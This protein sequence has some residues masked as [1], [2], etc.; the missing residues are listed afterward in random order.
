MV[1]AR[2]LG[3]QLWEGSRSSFEQTRKAESS[4]ADPMGSSSSNGTA[5]GSSLTY[6]GAPPMTKADIEH[7]KKFME[8]VDE[9][10]A[11]RQK[12]KKEMEK[13]SLLGALYSSYD[14]LYG[15][16]AIGDVRSEEKDLDGLDGGVADGEEGSTL[17]KRSRKKAKV[18]SQPP[19]PHLFTMVL[20]NITWRFSG[21]RFS[22]TNSEPAECCI[23]F[24]EDH[25]YLC[26]SNGLVT[27][28]DSEGVAFLSGEPDRSEWDICDRAEIP[29]PNTH[30]VSSMLRLLR[31]GILRCEVEGVSLSESGQVDVS[32]R[33]SLI[34]DLIAKSGRYFSALK[35]REAFCI[36]AMLS[37]RD[38]NSDE[39]QQEQL[40]VDL[41]F[42]AP[43]SEMNGAETNGH[44]HGVNEEVAAS[45][46]TSQEDKLDEEE[47][48]GSHP[49]PDTAT[50]A[51]DTDGTRKEETGEEAEGQA[52]ATSSARRNQEHNQVAGELDRNDTS[53]SALYDAIRPP[54][55]A[56]TM[57][58]PSEL[59]SK[60]FPYQQRALFWMCSREVSP[61]R[62]KNPLW[63]PLRL[64]NGNVLHYNCAEGV[65]QEIGGGSVRD[66]AGGIL[67]DE[68][69][70][71]KTVEVISLILAR[72]APPPPK[73][74]L[75]QARFNMGGRPVAEGTQTYSLPLDGY[76]DIWRRVKGTL[77]VTP[78]GIQYQWLEEISRHA[79]SLRVL[80]YEG[81]RGKRAV[82]EKMLSKYDVVLVTYAVLKAEVH[83]SKA[84]PYRFR[85]QKRYVV[86]RTPLLH[87]L[88]WRIVLDEAQMVESPVSASSRMASR[89]EAVH[90]WCVTGTPIG[91]Q[92]LDDLYG[93]MLFLRL[94]PYTVQSWWKSFVRLPSAATDVI[95][96]QT[97]DAITQTTNSTVDSG[98]R[99]DGVSNDLLVTLLRRT[100]W[101]HSK[102]HV[103]D[104]ISIPE[105]REETLHLTFSPVEEEYYKR[106]LRSTQ[107][108]VFLEASKGAI[109]DKQA[110]AKLETLRQV[111]CHPQLSK[112]FDHGPIRRGN[113][114]E[115]L[116]MGEIA[117]KMI[118]SAQDD[119][120]AAEREL[121]RHLNELGKAYLNEDRLDQA[122]KV[123]VEAFKIADAGIFNLDREGAGD[124]GERKLTED[125][126]EKVQIV[127]KNTQA[128]QWRIVE[129]VTTGV[130]LDAHQ[131][132]LES[133]V[134][135][136]DNEAEEEEL[137]QSIKKVKR[138]HDNHK[139]DVLELDIIKRQ[140]IEDVINKYDHDVLP[141]FQDAPTVCVE[142]KRLI[143]AYKSNGRNVFKARLPEMNRLHDR[144]TKVLSLC[145]KTRDV[146]FWSFVSVSFVRIHLH[147]SSP[148]GSAYRRV[149]QQLVALPRFN[150]PMERSGTILTDESKGRDEESQSVEVISVSSSSSSSTFSASSSLASSSLS[151]ER[152]STAG[153]NDANGL[154]V[155]AL[156]RIEAVKRVAA[157]LRDLSTQSPDKFA[158]HSRLVR[159]ILSEHG[160]TERFRYDFA[161]EL[162]EKSH[163]FYLS[164]RLEWEYAADSVTP[165]RVIKEVYTLYPKLLLARD[166]ERASLEQLKQDLITSSG[167]TAEALSVTVRDLRRVSIAKQNHVS[168]LKAKF[169]H[170]NNGPGG[171]AKQRGAECPICRR[172]MEKMALTWC[173]HEFCKGC[174]L[175][176][177]ARHRNCPSC[178]HNLT[179]D[180]IMEVLPDEIHRQGQLVSSLGPDRSAEIQS[181]AISGEGEYGTKVENLIRCLKLIQREDPNAKSLV[182]SQFSRLLEYIGHALKQ[183]DIDYI[184]MSGNSKSMANKMRSFQVEESSEKV[185]L[186][187]LRR[188]NSGRTL[189]SATH[190]FL[191]E[192][193]LSSAVE[194][195]A[196]NRVHRIGQTKVTYVH[197]LIVKSSVEEKIAQHISQSSSDSRD[198]TALSRQHK[199]EISLGD[200][201]SFLDIA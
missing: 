110:T 34:S 53:L 167:K 25:V 51:L 113:T 198:G 150:V 68:M 111:C 144:L 55:D 97:T 74:P 195:Q 174:I 112:S 156:W 180:S 114:T 100:M 77:I 193:S 26:L 59:Y 191:L 81:R 181:A 76:G 87:V 85:G 131:R 15:D 60:L 70:L 98:A 57:E 24:T 153:S 91:R 90:R 33:P 187:S 123:L 157:L 2:A 63:M 42:G 61:G 8:A 166:Q 189:V 154:E 155:F 93:L 134:S 103:E 17:R 47:L 44:G 118:S 41:S 143:E 65:V 88:W 199:E 82:S 197:R 18:Q 89:L 101:R 109:E 69:G 129:Y 49:I 9:S 170:L 190:V 5:V 182:F 7:E 13:D 6:A 67:A 30:K 194:L 148:S 58:Q 14:K 126:E 162:L 201:L 168:F 172:P 165:L 141:K 175:P 185:L 145:S 64:A 192:P 83:Y 107:S 43:D 163:Q 31:R 3:Q 35:T 119:L 99:S 62:M 1:Q 12:R 32:M 179:K 28:A 45:P 20:P 158:V 121:C 92:G 138:L 16:D 139:A 56:A 40:D 171:K 120:S 151:Q 136:G 23:R 96:T 135:G 196:I 95:A 164:A 38:P 173:G 50:A 52:T 149:L 176:W 104:E 161:G 142:T 27:E 19:P 94:D 71:G 124:S 66:V 169:Q 102:K 84:T 137:R 46:S 184:Y 72:P 86:P 39:E 54:P 188:D 36:I 200:L 125:L 78:M 73:P 37:L 159:P 75:F 80:I 160:L 177:I 21:V 4:P 146:A 178:R 11:R 105:L 115:L 108:S 106:S 79:P 132:R 186:M 29:T 127:T 130:L 117:K 122:E 22:T 48:N 133:F 147:S 183:N 152:K 116:K 128:R 140:E 10:T